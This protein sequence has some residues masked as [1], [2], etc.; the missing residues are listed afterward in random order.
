MEILLLK[1]WL[2]ASKRSKEGTEE[3][4]DEVYEPS[5]LRF[6][7]WLCRAPHLEHYFKVG[8]MVESSSF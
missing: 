6:V 7:A 3:K 5:Q 2:I 1:Q 8:V 4:A